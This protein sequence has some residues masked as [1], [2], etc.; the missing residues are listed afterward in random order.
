MGFHGISALTQG[1]GI[2]ETVCVFCIPFWTSLT[3]SISCLFRA[4][5]IHKGDKVVPPASF[6]AAVPP[7]LRTIPDEL[8]VVN[9]QVLEEVCHNLIAEYHLLIGPVASRVTCVSPLPLQNAVDLLT[10]IIDL[11]S[12]LHS[13]R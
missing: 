6:P 5:P 13:P 9:D 11:K 1:Q 4:D 12:L 10:R 2:S 3:E 8:P 7:D